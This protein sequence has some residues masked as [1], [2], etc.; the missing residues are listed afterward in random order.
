MEQL[1]I[2][3]KKTPNDVD[4]LHDL[5]WANTALKHFEKA[6]RILGQALKIEPE[7][8]RIVQAIGI[9]RMQQNRL[10]EAADHFRRA[11]QLKPDSPEAQGALKHV[12][13][14]MQPRQP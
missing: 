3:I 8:H 5:G 14:K 2:A 6:D 9:L 11:L 10:P 4:L 12:L 1:E 13:E 7:N